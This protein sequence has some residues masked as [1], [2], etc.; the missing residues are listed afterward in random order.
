MDIRQIETISAFIDA[1]LVPQILNFEQRLQFHLTLRRSITM[2]INMK[3][4]PI[5]MKALRP[6][7]PIAKNAMPIAMIG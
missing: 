2:P 1:S 4:S 6:L 3:A 5:A 7:K